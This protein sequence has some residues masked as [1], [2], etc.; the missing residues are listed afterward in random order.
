MKA[1]KDGGPAFPV[2]TNC[3]SAYPL[4]GMTMRDYFAAAAVQGILASTEA[5][6]AHKIQVK[7]L[8]E[9]CYIIA[10]ALLSQRAKTKEEQ[11]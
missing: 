2:T 11:P 7:N 10:D 5:S 1:L 6:Q 8:A 4:P 3:G 9:G